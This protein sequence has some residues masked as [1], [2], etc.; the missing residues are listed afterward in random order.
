MLVGD[1]L[2]L[3]AALGS[4]LFLIL[5]WLHAAQLGTYALLAW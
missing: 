2:F 1:R 5:R 3:R 4:C